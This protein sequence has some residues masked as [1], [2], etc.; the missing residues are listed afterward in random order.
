MK[1]KIQE[2]IIQIS[3]DRKK[4]LLTV[5]AACLILYL[6]FSLVLK[7]QT[8]AV[9]AFNIK[10]TKLK[11]ELK[12][13]DSDLAKMQ[14]SVDKPDALKDKKIISAG[15]IHWLIEEIY[16][17][18]SLHDVKIIQI[19]PARKTQPV[20]PGGAAS[21]PYVQLN[22]ELSCG[23]HPLVKFLNAL[24]N[25]SVIMV[26]DELEIMRSQKDIFFH[27]VRST[28]NVYIKQ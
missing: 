25:H 9:K 8:A 27:L 23:Y 19:I 4:L 3:Q 1:M 16:K 2:I 17:L 14:D 24:E 12:N 15:Q 28:L 26:V 7:S 21:S 22:M 10:V 11:S 6:D 18:A 13:L 5:I 20:A